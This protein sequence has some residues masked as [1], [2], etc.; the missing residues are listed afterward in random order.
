MWDATAWAA[1]VGPITT[2]I[3][4]LGGYLLAGRNEEKRDKR[5]EQREKTARSEALTER[6]DDQKHEI[7]R[8]TLFDLQDQLQRLARFTAKTLVF[9]RDT[10]CG[11]FKDPAVKLPDKINTGFYEAVRE[12]QRLRNRVL[13][14]RLRGAVDAFVSFCTSNVLSSGVDYTQRELGLNREYGK[15]TDQLGE[16]LRRELDRMGTNTN[17]PRTQDR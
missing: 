8:Q 5:T 9:D 12:V 15:V 10:E 1:V 2:M 6:R 11:R 17:P 4:G 14:E 3:S 13:D 7:Q 16:H